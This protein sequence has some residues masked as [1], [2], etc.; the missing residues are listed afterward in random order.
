MGMN[1]LDNCPKCGTLFVRGIR[2]LCNQCYQEEELEYQRVSSYLKKAENRQATIYEA[3][4]ATGVSIK[5]IT[6]FI[7]QK[8]I[9]LIDLPNMGYPC[10]SCGQIT[11]DGQLC[12]NCREQFANR[13][14]RELKEDQQQREQLKYKVKDTGYMAHKDKI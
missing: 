3:S 14:T 6:R 9:T 7:K 4:E 12:F 8:R 13:V 11:T 5:Q 2:D 1:Q 10:E